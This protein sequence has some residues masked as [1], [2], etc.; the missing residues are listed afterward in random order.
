LSAIVCVIIRIIVC[1]IICYFATSQV[2]S[3]NCA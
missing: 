3:L 2:L 1:V